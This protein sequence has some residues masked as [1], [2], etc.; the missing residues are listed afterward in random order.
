MGLIPEGCE[1]WGQFWAWGRQLCLILAQNSCCWEQGVGSYQTSPSHCAGTLLSPWGHDFQLIPCE[2]WL[3]SPSHPAHPTT[4]L[5]WR[6]HWILGW[7]GKSSD[8]LGRWFGLGD[9]WVVVSV[10]VRLCPPAAAASGGHNF[11][12]GTGQTGDSS[13]GT[14]QLG[15]TVSGHSP[16]VT[17]MTRGGW[18]GS[19]GS[20]GAGGRGCL[21]PHPARPPPAAQ[22][23]HAA[24][25][26][27]VH[28]RNL[29]ARG[30]RLPPCPLTP[31]MIQALFCFSSARRRGQPDGWR[32]L[33]RRDKTARLSRHNRSVRLLA[34]PRGHGPGAGWVLACPFQLP[35]L[36]WGSPGCSGSQ[37]RGRDRDRSQVS[38][39]I[40]LP[41]P[42]LAQ[43]DTAL[44]PGSLPCPLPSLLTIQKYLGRPQHEVPLMQGT[45]PRELLTFIHPSLTFPLTLGFLLTKF[46]SA[47]EKF[48]RS[49]YPGC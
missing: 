15:D 42:A 40:P 14:R 18:A 19:T 24:A 16:R 4:A 20:G 33:P 25:C 7:R 30:G 13:S 34:R 28:A 46:A 1:S 27:G 21:S 5:T 23:P 17:G 47:S 36:C 45:L 43:G 3:Q 44:R 49:Q 37:Q 31:R 9:T 48:L 32:W 11:R 39:L 10:L 35:Q 12:D 26:L 6:W 22:G 38:R 41:A 8:P 2:S 29:G